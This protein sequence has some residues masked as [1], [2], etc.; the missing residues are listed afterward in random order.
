[1]PDRRARRA[2]IWIVCGFVSLDLVMI[3]IG[4]LGLFSVDD[5]DVPYMFLI[6]QVF[7]QASLAA[8]WAVISIQRLLS[9]I[10]LAFLLT[11]LA[12]LTLA[13]AI[14]LGYPDDLAYASILLLGHAGAVAVLLL[15]ARTWS[16]ALERDGLLISTRLFQFSIRNT[17]VFTAA[18]ALVLTLNARFGWFEQYVNLDRS[19]AVAAW[20]FPTVGAV[21]AV[22]GRGPL[23]FRL[24]VLV[25]LVLTGM[26][27]FVSALGGE[28]SWDSD[29]FRIAAWTFP[30]LTVLVAIPLIIFR[31]LGYR[32]TR[33]RTSDVR[34][35]APA[36]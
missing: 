17:L 28:F 19:I 20:A 32:F 3:A 21:W 10:A 1:M 9:R 5:M 6:A 18:V 12:A 22:L 16:A 27:T 15:I 4:R 29:E 13:A 33:R 24:V 34:E 35:D 8:V 11:G 14:P 7:A 25:G 30:F 23:A 2:A 31:R 26:L 36:V